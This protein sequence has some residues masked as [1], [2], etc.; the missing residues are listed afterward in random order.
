MFKGDGGRPAV[1]TL[2][3]SRSTRVTCPSPSELE[4]VLVDMALPGAVLEPSGPSPWA[5]WSVGGG[6]FTLRTDRNS[7]GTCGWLL[8][9]RSTGARRRA[10]QL[11]LL[12]AAVEETLAAGDPRQPRFGSGTELLAA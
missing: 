12:A 10:D 3:V 1:R 8:V 4:V 9:E 11:D 7:D 5:E 2:P 6:R